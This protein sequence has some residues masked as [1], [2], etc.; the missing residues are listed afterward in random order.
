MAWLHKSLA[1][2]WQATS[3]IRSPRAYEDEDGTR[4]PLQRGGPRCQGHI[5]ATELEWALQPFVAGIHLSPGRWDVLPASGLGQ[6][7]IPSYHKSAVEDFRKESVRTDHT[8]YTFAW[9]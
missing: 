4:R 3:N 8:A 6:G 7:D 1:A 5:L 9:F 2:G